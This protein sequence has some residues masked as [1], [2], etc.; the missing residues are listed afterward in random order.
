[1]GVLKYKYKY[2]KIL[3]KYSTWGNVINYRWKL[4]T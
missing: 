3:V 1:M 4:N 2:L